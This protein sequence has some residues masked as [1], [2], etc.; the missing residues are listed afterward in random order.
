MT[1][2]ERQRW[3]AFYHDNP[4]L[5][6]VGVER[7]L[8]NPAEIFEAVIYGRALPL[9]SGMDHYP[10]LP[11]QRDVQARLDLASEGAR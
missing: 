11:A 9:P 6:R 10:L 2:R 5:S 8:D 4:D 1:A 3:T 7:F